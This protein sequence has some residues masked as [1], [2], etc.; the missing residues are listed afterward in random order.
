MNTKN[1]FLLLCDDYFSN[2]SGA[3]ILRDLTQTLALKGVKV[4]VITPHHK[5]YYKKPQLMPENLELRPFYF[6]T[7][8]TTNNVVRAFLE[9]L[10][11]IPFLYNALQENLKKEYSGLIYYSPSIFIGTT[12]YLFKKLFK[13]KT[14]LILRDIFP[15]WAVESKIIKQNSPIHLYF[16][17][18]SEISYNAADKIGV[19]SQSSILTLLDHG[20]KRGKIEVL[21]NWLS[22]HYISEIQPNVKFREENDL[23][24]KI[25]FFYA[26]NLGRAQHIESFF[27]ILEEFKAD[28][29]IAFAF[30]GS[31]E[32]VQNLKNIC[33]KIPNANYYGNLSEVEYYS[34]A[35]NL[36]VG[37]ICLNKDLK[38]SNYPGKCLGYM[39]MKKPFVGLMNP[40]NDMIDEIEE[41]KIGKV[42]YY[43]ENYHLSLVNTIKYLSKN[44]RKIQEMGDNGYKLL[45]QKYSSD[46]VSDQILLSLSINE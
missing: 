7:I 35:K 40:G 39:L 5:G 46:K 18:F 21:P 25:V 8:K 24:G 16:Q 6:P 2:R 37:L 20:I 27:P 41:H 13:I 10:S 11:I 22:D 12:V 34:I 28:K 23:K 19:M 17:Y 43:E 31:G 9:N 30:F 4:T 15:D 44:I 38:M 42:F 33:K 26:G 1:H 29:N 14:Y 36:D 32:S 3:Q 45:S